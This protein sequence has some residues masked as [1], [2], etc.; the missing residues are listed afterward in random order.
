MLNELRF[1][2]HY[3]VSFTIRIWSF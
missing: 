1:S 3:V 2:L